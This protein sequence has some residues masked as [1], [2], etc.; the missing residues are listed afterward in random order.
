MKLTIG[1]KIFSGFT[2][3]I[4]LL[5]VLSVVSIVNMRSMGNDSKEIDSNWMPAIQNITA[6][7]ENILEIDRLTLRVILEGNSSDLERL[8][9]DITSSS[10]KLANAKKIYVPT[11]SSTEEQ[12]IFD[13]FI[14]QEALYMKTLD[15]LW[16][17][18]RENN[19]SKA[20]ILINEN[21]AYY[22]PMIEELDQAIALNIEGANKASESSVNSYESGQTIVLI[23]SVIATL[24]GVLI[25]LFFGRMISRPI[26][27]LSE[28]AS[29][30][31]DG[32]MNVSID[33]R[34]KDEIGDLGNSFNTMVTNI[35]E[36]L[37]N[38]N[39]SS[40]QV[41]SGSRQVSDSS[42]ALSQGS[43]EQASSIEQLTASMEEISAQTRQNAIHANQANELSVAASENAVQGN[44]QM[45]QMLKAMEEINDSSSNI[46]KIIKVI[47]DIAF[48][49]NILAL[50]AA[51]EAAR[52]GQHGKG[53]AVVAEEVRN[54]A[55]RSASAAKETTAMIEGSI[56][57]VELGTKIA[58]DTAE[59]LV[60]IVDGV[61]KAGTLVASIASASN[62]QATGIAQV[63]QG[64]SQVSEVT[65]T[66]SATSEECAAASEELSSQAEL[67][68]EMV[69]KFKLRQ[70]G[71]PFNYD[72]L[73]P[74]IIRMLE[75][76]SKRE[77]MNANHQ[78]YKGSR[79]AA[80]AKSEVK[81]SLD[82]ME[83]GKY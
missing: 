21:R 29:R 83:F 71:S 13:A 41:A 58:N 38:I 25:A 11:I 74:D 81:I 61:A 49:T 3:I 66:N 20:K 64:I 63:N 50:N 51:V 16:A 5:I 18:G 48:Q 39:V 55:A 36:V 37:S 14:K 33:I 1:K 24:L 4:I 68:K 12:V 77:S 78:A 32:D 65:Q 31:A 59:A 62:E 79:Q 47:D 26:I 75:S 43:T 69:N 15:A 6:I 60:K 54:L 8:T 17:A 35:N 9:S 56:K 73:S 44:N 57:K 82:D 45:Q 67:L 19:I 46:S 30:M 7:K 42:Q 76:V 53:F 34:S 23:V 2:L 40:E 10:E 27:A 72:G 22:I 70:V 52:A 28:A 80:A